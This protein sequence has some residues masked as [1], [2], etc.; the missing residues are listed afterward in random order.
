MCLCM[1]IDGKLLIDSIN[2][3]YFVIVLIGFKLVILC[4]KMKLFFFVF[5]SF[6]FVN[7]IVIVELY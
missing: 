4:E 6:F 3:V 1:V 5:R 2:E 7:K